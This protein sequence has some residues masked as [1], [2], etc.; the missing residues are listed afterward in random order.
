MKDYR[1]FKN[2]LLDDSEIRKEYERLGP[3]Y[4]LIKSV[5][6]R[7]LYL[8]LSQKDLA[9]KMNTKQSA[10][11]RLESGNYNPSFDF[12]QKVAGALDSKLEVIIK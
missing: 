9:V 4:Q 11:S 2:K 1:E 10:V 5:I 7:R 6:R 12:I 3:K 8:G